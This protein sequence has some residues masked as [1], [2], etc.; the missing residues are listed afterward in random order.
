MY[1]MAVFDRLDINRSVQ[2]Q[3]QTTCEAGFKSQVLFDITDRSK[4]LL[5][6]WCSVLLVLVSVS[7]LFHLLRVY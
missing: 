6:M 3:R 5:L 7:V 1:V 4:A 2:L